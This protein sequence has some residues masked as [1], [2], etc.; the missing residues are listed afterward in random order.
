MMGYII[1]I[2][3][4]LIP[5]LLR[6]V[7]I[8]FHVTG[9]PLLEERQLLHGRQLRASAFNVFTTNLKKTERIKITF[10]FGCHLQFMPCLSATKM[11]SGNY[12]YFGIC[13]DIIKWV[14]EHFQME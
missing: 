13:N 12:S 6:S 7:P 3:L 8:K 2:L 9:S 1:L 11:S 4:S 14:S 5:L 10:S